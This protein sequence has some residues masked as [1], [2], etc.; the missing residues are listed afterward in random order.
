MP[1]LRWKPLLVAGIGSGLVQVAAGMTMYVLGVYFAP[2]SGLVSLALLAAALVLGVWWYVIHV[3]HR[4]VTYVT[5]LLAGLAIAVA[6]GLVYA[7]YNVLSVS[8][9][10][11]HFLEDMAEARVAARQAGGL[12]TA[13]AAEL[14][15]SLRASTTLASVVASNLRAFCL[16]GTV[17][18]A[19][20][21]LGFRSAFPPRSRAQHEPVGRRTATGR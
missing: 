14:L 8:F 2:W 7:T 15:A 6:T 11:P 18:S 3:L 20:A 5:A 9:V 1:A 17:V 12:D 16:F 19:L 10:Y 21:A 13:H 4:Q